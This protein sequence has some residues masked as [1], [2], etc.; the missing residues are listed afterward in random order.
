M[1]GV[2]GITAGPLSAAPPSERMMANRPECISSISGCYTL[3]NLANPST[4][5]TD[6]SNN[7]TSPDWRVACQNTTRAQARRRQTSHCKISPQTMGWHG[8]GFGHQSTRSWLCRLITSPAAYQLKVCLEGK[9]GVPLLKVSWYLHNMLPAC[10][11]ACK[12]VIFCVDQP[13][14]VHKVRGSYCT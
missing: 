7:S 10:Y 3:P 14:A 13:L 12:Q 9:C 2:V 4:T 8:S 6:S 5:L 1:I 11:P